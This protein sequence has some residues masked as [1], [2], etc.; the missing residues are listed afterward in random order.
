MDWNKPLW[1]LPAITV[2]YLLATGVERLGVE[3]ARVPL[4]VW[5]L[6]SV[7]LSWWTAARTTPALPWSLE[8][9]VVLMPF[10]LIGAWLRGPLLGVAA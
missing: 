5:V 8:R 3:L 2:A 1:F 10:F 4:P 9:V 6:A 7:G